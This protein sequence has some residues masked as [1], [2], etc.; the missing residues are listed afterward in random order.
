LNITGFIE[1]IDVEEVR[2]WAY[3]PDVPDEKLEIIVSLDDL[4]VGSGTAA[5]F[6]DD[7]AQLGFGAGDHAFAVKLDIPV[8]VAD[9]DQIEVLV[10]MSDGTTAPLPRAR[11]MK[12]EAVQQPP[13]AKALTIF[14]LPTSDP[15]H[16]PAFILGAARSGTSAV[17]QA[18]LKCGAYGG[19]EEGHFLWLVRR[20]LLTVHKYYEDNGEDALPNRFT[21]LAHIPNTYLISAVRATFIAAM[22]EMFPDGRWLDKTPRAEMI[23][24]APIMQELWPNARFV[25][26]KRR[27]LE[28]VSSRLSKFPTISFRQHCK[29]W[30]RSMN[31]WLLVRDL[32]GG[33]AIE[34]EQL[35][36]A[37]APERSAEALGRF[38]DL[39]DHAVKRLA[40]SF[41]E[42]RPEQTTREFAPVM[43]IDR[44]GWTDAM[45]TEF[46]A[47]CGPMMAA[48]GYSYT[49]R[50]F[51]A[52]VAAIGLERLAK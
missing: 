3:L 14:P 30:A 9:L 50:Y 26:M 22:Q 24:V 2:G 12:V 39:P 34:V 10:R 49:D 47:V 20:F 5:T 32:L 11:N 44:L 15:A 52:P 1:L 27:A 42:D 48:Y 13:R 36:I 6:R 16:H 31:A 21:M 25:F 40:K 41:S 43:Q 23:E 28:N 46:R 17:A 33:A 29:D 35:A 19:F 38:L 4:T 7:L 51:A 18:L 8:A 37:Q 45:I